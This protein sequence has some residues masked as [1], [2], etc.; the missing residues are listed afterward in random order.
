MLYLPFSYVNGLT[1]YVLIALDK[2]KTI[3]RFFAITAV[4]NV[5]ANLALIPRFGYVAASAVTVGSEV[6][7]LAPLWWLTARELG[8][9]SLAR[10]AA[11]PTLAALASGIVMVA[12]RAAGMP[13]LGAI[14]APLFAAFAGAIAYVLVLLALRTFTEE[15]LALVRKVLGRKPATQAVSIAAS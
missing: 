2:Q 15:E 6:V 14:A 11:R 4:F 5:A 8:G 9:T 7:L 13:V 3:V 10:T 12:L 1:Q